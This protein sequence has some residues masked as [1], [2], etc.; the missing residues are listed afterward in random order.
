MN[1][2]TLTGHPIS[3]PRITPAD[4]LGLTMF[5]AIAIH[6]IVILGITFGSD[7]LAPKNPVQTMEITLVQSRSET[8]PDE[9][10]QYLAQ[11]NQQG[12]GNNIET[13]RP[14]AR[15]SEVVKTPHKTQG[16]SPNNA[17]PVLPQQRLQ[18]QR[19]REVLTATTSPVKTTSDKQASRTDSTKPRAST[20]IANAL[21]IA[22]ASAELEAAREANKSKQ[23]IGYITASTRESKYAAYMDAWRSKVERIGR[24]NYPEEARRR[25]LSGNLILTVVLRH[26]GTVRDIEVDQSSGNKLLDDAA[27]RIVRLAAPFAPF[28]EN[29][30]VEKDVLYMTRTWIFQDG[31]SLSTR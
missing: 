28:P 15:R 1:Q 25:K 19:Q 21:Q 12:S 13:K 14:E 20:L 22:S 4:R 9:D 16:T 24:I 30:R 23:R 6:A 27:R 17:I 11:A 31:N 3:G 18:Q 7:L 26:D 8:P 10:A 5:F 29:I 2:A